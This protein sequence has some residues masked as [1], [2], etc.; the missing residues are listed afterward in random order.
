VGVEFRE[1]SVP[2]AYRIRLDPRVDERGLFMEW[3]QLERFTEAIGQP[4]AIRQ[5]NLSVSRRGVLRGVHYADVPPGQAKYVTAVAGRVLDFVVDLRVGS[6][7]FGA[8]DSVVLDD[9]D[10]EAVYLA[11]GLGHAF[12]A[13]SET[14]TVTYLVNETYNPSAEHTV[15][16]LDP[17]LGLILP[18]ELGEP[19]LSDR[20]RSAPSLL[21]ALAAGALP[22]WDAAQELSATRRREVV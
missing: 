10:R 17:E 13:L 12:V 8:W 5:A 15:D 20:D 6:P 3:F 14:A 21:E 18:D 16:A 19:I 11:E 9:V 1:L 7:R 2:D 4:L 22:A